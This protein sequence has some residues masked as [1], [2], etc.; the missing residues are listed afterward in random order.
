LEN[1]ALFNSMPWLMLGL[2]PRF[3]VYPLEPMS[4]SHHPK[5]PANVDYDSASSFPVTGNTAGGALYG[6]LKFTEPWIGGEGAYVGEKIVILGGSSSV[7]LYSSFPNSKFLS[8]SKLINLDS[9]PVRRTCW[10]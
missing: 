1:E 7:G 4:H 10:F 3:V 6:Q 5:I 9:Y 2:P 8:M